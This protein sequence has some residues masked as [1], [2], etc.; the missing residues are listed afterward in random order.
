MRRTW[1]WCSEWPVTRERDRRA[2]AR[3][4]PASLVGVWPASEMLRCA[5]CVCSRHRVG[6]RR[7][8]SLHLLQH[9]LVRRDGGVALRLARKQRRRQAADR[10]VGVWTG[11]VD[12]AES[13]AV[14]AARRGDAVT[15]GPPPVVGP[16]REEVA[17]VDRER[18]GGRGHGDP[19]VATSLDLEPLLLSRLAVQDGKAA[20]AGSAGRSG[21]GTRCPVHDA[22]RAVGRGRPARLTR[23]SLCARRTA[24]PALRRRWRRRRSPRRSEGT[25]RAGA[26]CPGSCTPRRT[27]PRGAAAR[28]RSAP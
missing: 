24:T 19:V 13:A 25:T 17:D 23:Q 5:L 11:E 21:A 14:G 3:A 27:C 12:D 22:G 26:A 8:R 7:R 4:R 9:V 20:R 18:A 2:A 6:G 10:C 28:A 1:E 16:S 15:S